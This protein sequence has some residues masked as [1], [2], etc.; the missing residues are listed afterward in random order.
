[1]I[2]TFSFS[3]ADT[4]RCYSVV[5]ATSPIEGAPGAQWNQSY[6]AIWPTALRVLPLLA[7]ALSVH[8]DER[9]VAARWLCFP[10]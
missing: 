8:L 2:P 1:M 9:R 3:K 10:L 6:I 5:L 7:F 4:C